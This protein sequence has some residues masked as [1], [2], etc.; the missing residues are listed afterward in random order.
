[1]NAE[2][3]KNVII[4]YQ[5]DT[6]IYYGDCPSCGQRIKS[7]IVDP[8]AITHRKMKYQA[9]IICPRCCKA[10]DWTEIIEAIGV[11]K[12]NFLNVD[13]GDR[14]HAEV[15]QEAVDKA[16]GTLVTLDC[17]ISKEHDCNGC[18]YKDVEDWKDPCRICRRI[19]KDYY[20]KAAE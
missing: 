6:S 17:S 4:E 10:M 15:F 16:I 8:I 3:P 1:M 2:K 14:S 5:G 7:K 18:A 13:I 9:F 12:G 11:L 20:R 19:C